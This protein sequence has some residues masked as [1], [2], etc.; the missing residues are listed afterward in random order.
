MLGFEQGYHGHN[1][2]SLPLD[3]TDSIQIYFIEN[4]LMKIDSNLRWLE[5]FIFNLIFSYH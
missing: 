1:V 2:M 5:S 4:L 3:D